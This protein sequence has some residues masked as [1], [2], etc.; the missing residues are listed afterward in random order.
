M[1]EAMQN[2]RLAVQLEPNNMEY[3][4]ALA[5]MQQG[6]VHYQRYGTH[7]AATECDPCTYLCFASLTPWGGLCC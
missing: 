6:G 1:D 4:Q 2:Y 7:G 3:R 5:M